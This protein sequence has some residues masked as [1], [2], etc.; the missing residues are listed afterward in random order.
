MAA[1]E[2]VLIAGPTASGKSR[3]ALELARRLDGVV[4]NADSMQVYDGLSILTARPSAADMAAVPHDLYGHVNPAEAYSAGAYL[5][6]AAASLAA[7]KSGGRLP[8]V[9]GGTGL[10][11]KALLGL[12]DTMPPVPAAIREHWR[13]RLAAEGAAALHGLLAER[14][15]A[16][17][18]RIASADGQR[19]VRALE[20]GEASGRTLSA[21]QA[22]RGEGPLSMA[23]TVKVVLTP[24]RPVLRERIARR[25]ADMLAEG[26]VAEVAAFRAMPGAMGGSA[27]RAIGVDELGAVIDGSLDLVAA[28]ERAVTRTRQY[29]KRQETWFRHQFGPDW[30]RLEGPDPAG[31]EGI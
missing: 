21:L 30:Q 13:G 3:L 18:A 6:D 10:Y 9:C 17:A 12:L 8:I 1:V 31:I 28:R 15:P 20:V 27:A 23:R 16:A 14:D 25:F 11:F 29:A 19:I 5:R 22:G 26:A 4:V 7:A 24:E 2:A